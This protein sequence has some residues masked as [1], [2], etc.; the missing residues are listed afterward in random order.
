M[1]K[2]INQKF[3]EWKEQNV[4]AS[5]LQKGLTLVELLVVIVIIGVIAALLV[6][7]VTSI[8]GK[9]DGTE[10]NQNSKKMETAILQGTFANEKRAIPSEGVTAPS[11]TL[12][13]VDRFTGTTWTSGT[14]TKSI[15]SELDTARAIEGIALSIGLPGF[16][17]NDLSALLAPI[18]ADLVKNP[19]GKITSDQYFVVL[20]KNQVFK[21]EALDAYSSYNDELAGRVISTETVIDSD[22]NFFNGSFEIKASNMK[23]IIGAGDAIKSQVFAPANGSSVAR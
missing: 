18:D 9:V 6:L 14:V 22:G 8:F 3:R 23:P 4:E 10:L 20:N 21:D 15:S 17:G 7:A 13:A 11:A 19:S 2:E 16:E 12:V 1:M 5:M